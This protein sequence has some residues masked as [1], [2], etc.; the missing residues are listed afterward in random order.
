MSVSPNT[1]IIH[2]DD[3]VGKQPLLAAIIEYKATIIYMYRNIN[4]IAIRIPEGADIE[5]AI[6]YFSDVEGVLQVNRDHIIVIDDP[7]Y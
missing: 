1:L 6:D 7:I 2:Y 5:E 4:G 3:E